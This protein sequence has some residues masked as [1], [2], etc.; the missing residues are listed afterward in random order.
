MFVQ[1]HADFFRNEYQ[2]YVKEVTNSENEMSMHVKKC[3]D[4]CIN[5]NL[6][7]RI[8]QMEG[9]TGI[10]T[11]EFYNRLCSFKIPGRKTEYLE[12]GTWKGSSFVSAMY[13][14]CDTTHGTVIDNWSEFNT[15]FQLD[16]VTKLP[17]PIDPRG[18]FLNN[19][20]EFGIT[21]VKVI[22]DDFFKVDLKSLEHPI[23]IYL[24]DG[25]HTYEDQYKA[26]THAW[27]VLSKNAI[28]VVD[29]WSWTE[30]KSGTM[31][32]L[33]DVGANIKYMFE[34]EYPKGHDSHRYGFWNGIGVIVVG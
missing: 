21:D 10:L 31:D 9:M 7:D 22:E 14:N 29:D 25:G 3:I 19:I 32:G 4:D 5:V 8:L 1:H 20:N 24:Y 17:W 23:D 18:D 2:P 16:P 33:R 34:V 11:R 30:V 13:K 15:S 12:V 27:P 28:I 6:P 26:I